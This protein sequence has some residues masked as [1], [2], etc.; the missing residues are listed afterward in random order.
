MKLTIDYCTDC[1][2]LGKAVEAA[3]EI[4]ENY[5]EE[6]DK[7]ELVPSEDGV[8]RISIESEIV[9]DIDENSFSRAEVKTRVKDFIEEQEE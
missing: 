6:F 3:E 5:P 4:L 8:L 1:G 2:H 7:V 9:F